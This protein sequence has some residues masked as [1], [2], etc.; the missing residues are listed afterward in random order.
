PH[1]ANLIRRTGFI[2][3]D[4]TDILTRAYCTVANNCVLDLDGGGFHGLGR[5][6]GRTIYTVKQADGVTPAV[7]QQ[8]GN[9]TER[10]CLYLD[11][12]Y[13]PAN[14]QGVPTPQPFTRS[15]SGATVTTRSNMSPTGGPYQYWINNCVFLE[16]WPVISNIAQ[17]DPT[18]AT[19]NAATDRANGR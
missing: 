5:T 10:F 8:F 13:G 3:T 12:L 11:S 6:S 4:A 2:T 16:P 1:V 14:G 19:G 7:N 15:D 9:Q 17:I 18:T